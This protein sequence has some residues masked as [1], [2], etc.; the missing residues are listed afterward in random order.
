MYT[1]SIYTDGTNRIDLR[2][3]GCEAAYAA[4][5]MAC[6]MAE[7]TGATVDLWDSETG[8]VLACNGEDE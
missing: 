8:E 6:D 5:R 1:V 2:V 7:L 4:Y 3:D